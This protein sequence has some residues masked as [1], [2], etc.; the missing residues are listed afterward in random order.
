MIEMID[1]APPG[2]VAFR[3]TGTLN[4]DDLDAVTGAVDAAL[5][6]HER[7]GMYADL[8]GFSDLTAEALAKDLR[9]SLSKLGELNRF[10]RAAVVTD[11]QWI[12]A[13][14]AMWSPLLPGVEARAFD[15]GQETEAIA[16]VAGFAPKK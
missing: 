8:T 7:I 9:Y 16:W 2:V 13:M 11:K 3:V 14:T 10:P 15:P 4:G 6:R 12:K 5:A 1:N